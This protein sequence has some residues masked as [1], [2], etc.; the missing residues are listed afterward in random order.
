MKFLGLHRFSAPS[1]LAL[2][3]L[4]TLGAFACTPASHGPAAKSAQQDAR[5]TMVALWGWGQEDY[6]VAC[7]GVRLSED[8]IAIPTAA[9]GE[10]LAP[11]WATEKH[12]PPATNYVVTAPWQ[13]PQG[14]SRTGFSS[15]QIGVEG[16]QPPKTQQEGATLGGFVVANSGG[17]VVHT[18]Q[19]T[20]TLVKIHP[21]TN[22]DLDQVGAAT[23][24]KTKLKGTSA[25]VEWHAWDTERRAD[26]SEDATNGITSNNTFRE[27]PAVLRAVVLDNELPRY[28]GETHAVLHWSSEVSADEQ[29]WSWANNDK[30]GLQLFN[31]VLH[32]LENNKVAQ[33]WAPIVLWSAG[34]LLN[35]W[36]AARPD[37]VGITTPLFEAGSSGTRWIGFSSGLEY[38]HSSALR[39]MI[40]N[41]TGLEK[42]LRQENL[43]DEGETG[44]DW[45]EFV[46]KLHRA[47]LSNDR[48]DVAQ[49][50]W[51]VPRTTVITELTEDINLNVNFNSVGQPTPEP[52]L[53]EQQQR[54]YDSCVRD[55]DRYHQHPPFARFVLGNASVIQHVCR[56]AVTADYG[57][58]Y[59]IKALD[60]YYAQKLA[61][62]ESI[63]RGDRTDEQK[64]DIK[65]LKN[66]LK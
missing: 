51:L 22:C 58:N 6:H 34:T 15:D 62:L 45:S 55:I 43:G 3:T 48:Y 19:G 61:E 29:G 16:C 9:C 31:N 39:N 46:T 7:Y 33:R 53:T 37:G 28:V 65:I 50:Q 24:A 10:A 18:I 52:E 44:E 30:G 2:L 59:V 5:T 26:S 12:Y 38:N 41:D 56:D 42:H 63:P 1:V 32:G 21:G 8:T 27:S 60:A 40:D 66:A 14:P 47:L 13:S 57:S 20:A 25:H 23:P 17:K 35:E 54:L 4:G 11:V 64:Q 36:D 49:T